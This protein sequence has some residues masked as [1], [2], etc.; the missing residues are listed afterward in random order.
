MKALISSQLLR[1]T[2][3]SL[4]IGLSPVFSQNSSEEAS[5][6]PWTDTDTRLA[7]HYLKLL[8]GDPAYG[9]VLNLL[10]NLYEKKE[11]TPL[12]LSYIGNAA[13]S[14]KAIPTLIH[15]H[16]LRKNEQVDEARES[17]GKVLDL[18]PANPHA[19]RALAEI[20]DLQGRT[21]KALSFYH[22]LAEEV[23]ALDEN[24]VAFRLRMAA[25]LRER[26][27]N[28]EALAIWTELLTA[29]PEDTSLRNQ[30][31]S[32]LL[33]AGETDAALE[34]LQSLT[35]S[36]SP[37]EQLDALIELTTLYEF[38]SD[39]EGAVISAKRGLALLHF[40]NHDYTALF[41]QWVQI[42]ERFERLPDLEE[43][44]TARISEVN[45]TEQ[46]LFDLAEFY[47]LTA[48]PEE[49]E[50]VTAN[51][52]ELLPENL[53]YRLRLT[54]I[55]MRNDRYEAAAATLE[56]A[57]AE[58]AEVPLHLILLRARIALNDDDRLTAREIVEKHLESTPLNKDEVAEI[59]AFA[60][61]NYLDGLVER[62][63]RDSYDDAIA[64]ANEGN[65]PADLARFLNERGRTGQ[66]IET[67]N[68]FIEAAGES[69]MER[70]RRLYRVSI[71]LRELDEKQRALDAIREAISLAPEKQEYLTAQAD[72]LVESGEIK[73]AI[74]LL[75]SLRENE[76]TVERRADLDQRLFSLLRGHFSTEADTVED[77]SL[78]QNGRIQS[79]AQYRRIAAA[80]SQIG[81]SGD[82]PP[83]AE[84]VAYYDKIKSAASKTPST[85]NRYR[86]AWWALKLQD[87]QECYEQLTKATEE[88]GSPVLEV[89]EMLLELAVQNERPT[90]MIQH[91]TALS[92][93]DAE[94]ADEYLQRRAEMRF[95]LGFEDEAI[96]ELKR[97]AAKPDA[98]L[99]TL[100]T[101]AKVYQRQG[102]TSRQLEVWERAYREANVFEKRR[103]VKQ[104]T[105]TLI[106]TG[107]P[108]GALEAQ[109]ELIQGETDLIQ[110]R[111]QLDTQLST[112]RSH[113]LLEWLLGKYRDLAQQNPF[114]RFYPEALARVNKAAGNDAASFEAM[115]KAYYMSGQD[116][117]LLNELG[118]LAD[119]MGDL[120]SAIYYRRQLLAREEGEQLEN[121]LTLIEMLE[122]D[123]RVDEA[124]RLRRRLEGRFGRDPEFLKELT[125]HYLADGQGEAAERTLSKIVELRGWDLQSRLRLGL[126]LIEH[127]KEAEA[128]PLLEQLLEDTA[129]E[130]YPEAF[131]ARALPL[132]RVATL[133][134]EDRGA[135][136]TELDPFIFSIESYP[137]MGGDLQDD[138]AE[139][140]QDPHPEFA[141]TPDEPYLIRLRALEEAASLALRSGNSGSWLRSRL[142][143]SLPLHERLWAA[144]HA[145][146]R[147]AFSLLLK[148]LPEPATHLEHFVRAYCLLL[149]GNTSDLLEWT[150]HQ[151]EG[152]SPRSLYLTM[153]SLVLLKDLPLD[154]LRSPDFL[155]DT[156]TRFEVPGAVATH[157]F[158]ELRAS[159]DYE[160]AYQVGKRFAVEPLSEHGSFLFALSQVA[161]WSGHP[162]ERVRLL[163][164]SLTHLRA[165]S[166]AGASGHFLIAL[167]EKLS[168]L[169]NDKSR[170]ELLFSLKAHPHLGGLTTP[171]DHLERETLISLAGRDTLA[172]TEAI[173]RLTQ[174]QLDVMRPS[175]PD[176]DQ[177]RHDQ[178]QSWQRMRQVLDFYSSRL[179]ITPENRGKILS[180]FKG[181]YRFVPTD[182]TVLA[183]FERFEI[184]RRLLG[185]ESMSFSER[186]ALVDEMHRLFLEP[187]SALDLARALGNRGFNREAIPVYLFEA[188]RLPRDYTP[189]QGV[190]ESCAE[191]LEPEPALQLINRINAREYPAPPGLTSDYLAEQHALFLFMSRDLDRL[192]SLG[193]SPSGASGSPPISSRAHLPYQA[194]LVEAYRLMG[195]DDALLRLLTFFRNEMTITT[196]QLLLGASVLESKER[197][198]EALDW[199]GAIQRDGTEPGLERRALVGAAALHKKLGWPSPAAVVE[200]AHESLENH[201]PSVTRELV[202]FA[203]ESGGREE[204]LSILR[205]LRRRTSNPAQRAA[206]SAQSLHLMSGDD[207][208]P[209]QSATMWQAYFQDFVYRFD[210]LTASN[211]I[212]SSNASRLVEWGINLPG[213]ATEIADLIDQC[214]ARGDSAWLSSLLSAALKN[215][216]GPT[217]LNLL[218]DSGRSTQQKI[219]ETLPAF[220]P[221]GIEAAKAWVDSSGAVGTSFLE[222]QPVRQILFFHRIG[223]RERLLEVHQN[224][225]REA[226][227][228]LF[229]QSGL[230]SWF[231][232]LT[233]RY[234]L[235][236]LLANLGEDDL[237]ARLFDRYHD[238][239]GPYLWN[240]QAFLESYVSFLI[241]QSQFEKAESILKRV[242]QKT[243]RVDLRLLVQLYHDWGKLDEWETRLS[244][245]DLSS[246]RRA[247]LHDWSNALAEGR[248]M[249]EYRD[250]W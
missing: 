41:S 213:D 64:G 199:L 204:A 215:E 31:V 106:E 170:R 6:I 123:L 197:Y 237:A 101:L 61:E 206:I 54:G 32:Q 148:Q 57:L 28:P 39:F 18:D 158:S 37:R 11:Q 48:S 40:K 236:A 104:L 167:T 210:E 137:F 126:L 129:D 157:L 164:E 119:Q 47:R 160:G 90:L 241:D 82:D 175:H 91:L 239:S 205:I 166:G 233:T 212:P 43:E 14:E 98:S 71:I 7:N 195:R 16:L 177:V 93:I 220:G 235:P 9:K 3:L 154:P 114:D 100:N 35:S 116:E 146:D 234:R 26:A 13:T 92:E 192:I 77:D 12:L 109:L 209:E 134:A 163:D 203:H 186:Q 88:A 238:F 79:L 110:R 217:A 227:S 52:V 69:T 80:A 53:D 230:D 15:A 67:L 198:E 85:A 105:T 108:E 60:R 216:L 81:R 55:Q 63:L 113:F 25:L 179:F 70:S 58:Q 183:E 10:W 142:D 139:A 180:A 65:A 42:H 73:K 190:F 66:A 46:A 242:A 133:P 138:I 194:A 143:P 131:A 200:L 151:K 59:L 103:I 107:N 8:Q 168:L 34:L 30:I 144:R 56:K 83:P 196:P 112:A 182:E 211:G 244:D 117:R 147:Q 193:R 165:R 132:I 21:S 171:S 44:L 218:G 17:Y 24:G 86:A 184:D 156:L 135:P 201:P 229:H 72:L 141:Y 222:H 228:D 68:A 149:T 162:E 247:L 136:G 1:V 19:L 176:P 152:K 249:V 130:V 51:L 23:P 121:W 20:A 232:T 208:W 33:E 96:R 150:S 5:T 74:K 250:S 97:L 128:A 124:N 219:L 78:L 87:N 231:P 207:A 245:V 50:R 221:H 4:A 246:G 102:N 75:E 122:K 127:E 145:G 172:A 159:G 181:E 99:N 2:A 29:Y 188:M 155:Y 118:Q 185:F 161:G 173:A 120:K 22:R 38:I 178:S 187:D 62:L 153:A 174:R 225:M 226:R 224:L 223:D 248:E 76:E 125:E 45:P 243:I 115:K 202:D 49:E 240:H 84:L 36:G 189:L 191:A 111:K 140:L 169:D 27:R 95:E 89:E 214:P 94:N